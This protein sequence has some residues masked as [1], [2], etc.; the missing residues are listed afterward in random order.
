MVKDIWNNMGNESAALASYCVLYEPCFSGLWSR[1]RRVLSSAIGSSLSCLCTD[2][3]TSPADISAA[4]SV[5][6]SEATAR[7][8]TTHHPRAGKLWSKG[9]EEE[10]GRSGLCASSTIWYHL[11]CTEEHFGTAV[12]EQVLWW[13]N[14]ETGKGCILFCSAAKHTGLQLRCCC[15]SYLCNSA[16]KDQVQKHFNQLLTQ[17]EKKK[18]P[19]PNWTGAALLG[20]DLAKTKWYSEEIQAK[21]VRM[22]PKLTECR[23]KERRYGEIMLLG[24][25]AEEF[26]KSAID[27]RCNT[28]RHKA[29]VS[30]DLYLSCNIQWVTQLM[31]PPLSCVS[32]DQAVQIIMNNDNDLGL[33]ANLHR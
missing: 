30:L 29:Y 32:L 26:Q 19:N 18:N 23:G 16:K 28:V 17:L 10:E 8:R 25:M 5:G 33:R 31:I 12:V 4:A 9:E 15:Y 2:L 21:M 20:R 22:W 6:T 27:Y 7:C 24:W 13:E 1:L 11:S 14:R 3:T